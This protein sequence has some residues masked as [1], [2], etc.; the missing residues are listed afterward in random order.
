MQGTPEREVDGWLT[1]HATH[2]SSRWYLSRRGTAVSDKGLKDIIS[3]AGRGRMAAPHQSM[4]QRPEIDYLRPAMYARSEAGAWTSFGPMPLHEA[5]LRA[6]RKYRVN[7]EP[8]I[9]CE[10]LSLVGINSILAVFRRSDF[11]AP[12]LG[13][14]KSF[15]ERSQK[16]PREVIRPVDRAMRAA[17]REEFGRG[18]ESRNVGT[19]GAWSP[20]DIDRPERR[21]A[22]SPQ[23]A[24]R[25]VQ[26]E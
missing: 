16:R 24:R 20:R 6:V 21:Q 17:S 19:G 18:F 2:G 15:E 26:K 12:S 11:P 23:R 7:H 25:P 14:S 10:G 3:M 4:A 22:L 8:C 9:F 5:V 13:K 1:K